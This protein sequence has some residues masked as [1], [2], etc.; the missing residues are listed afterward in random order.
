MKILLCNN[1]GVTLLELI[2]AIGIFALLA[3]GAGL[4]LITSIRSNASIWDHLEVQRDGRRAVQQVVNDIRRAEQSSVGAYMI[5]SA[6]DNELII[7]SNIDRKD[8]RERVR[9]FLQGQTLKKGIT[10]P[11]GNPLTYVTSTESVID[12]ANYVV[13]ASS[14]QPI[15]FYY[16]ATYSGTESTMSPPVNIG[17]IRIIRVKLLLDKNPNLSPTVLEVESVAQ[18]RNLKLN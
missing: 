13:N 1:R 6:G 10:I 18:L 2:V 5:A 16:D 14:S 15:F 17:N 3:M 9:Y 11:T 12:V 8:Y 7:Y 4:I